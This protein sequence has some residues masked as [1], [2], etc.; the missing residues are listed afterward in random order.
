[1]L[2][3]L[4][5]IQAL[6]GIMSKENASNDTLFSINP[7]TFTITEPKLL[8]T[9]EVKIL[10]PDGTLVSDDIVGKNNGFIFQ[11]EKAIEPAS[12][13]LQGF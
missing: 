2:K 13:P 11:V 4:S 8:S 5:Q 1:M 12:I 3:M 10:N 9:I 7:I 6:V